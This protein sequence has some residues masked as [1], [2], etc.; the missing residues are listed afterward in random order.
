[1][2]LNK[3]NLRT[4]LLLFITIVIA[5]L[6]VYSNYSTSMTAL[7]N[8]SPLAAM[9]LFGGS[10]FK[11][12]IKPFLFPIITI[13]IS[14]LFLFATVY[15]EYGNG[16]LYDGWAWVYSAFV[17]MAL[18]GKYI[19]R[20]ATIQHIGIAILAAIC[21]H[22]L[23]TD[24]GVWLGS[25]TYPQTWAGFMACLAA[26]IPFEIRLLVSTVVYSVVMF[27]VFELLQKKYFVHNTANV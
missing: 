11:G 19:I 2:S 17:L 25:K 1:M 12:N 16:F 23:L 15:K 5:A 6:R 22:W 18:C 9:A 27:G 8:Y 10:Y 21:I 14:D 3:I 7:A 24:F 4:A 26:A 13:F 20:T